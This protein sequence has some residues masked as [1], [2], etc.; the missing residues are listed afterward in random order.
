MTAITKQPHSRSLHLALKKAYFLAIQSGAKT[1]EYRLATP[2]WSKRL[3]NR[4]YEQISLTMGYPSRDD[5]SRRLLRPW[6]GCVKQTIVHP[7]FGDLPVTVFAI[8]LGGTL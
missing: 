4:E 1:V 5:Q 3:A 7:H 8:A 2:Y 6:R